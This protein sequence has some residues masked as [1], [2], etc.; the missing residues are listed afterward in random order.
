VGLGGGEEAIELVGSEAHGGGVLADLGPAHVG[1]GR[2]LE[3]FGISDAVVVE[4]R[5]ARQA[6][7]DRRRRGRP[8]GRRLRDLAEMT[9][10]GVDVM[11]PSDKGGRRVRRTRRTRS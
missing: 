10:P 8:S 5:Q 7:S 3:N 1:D 9:D 6:P 11:A 4:L 2:V